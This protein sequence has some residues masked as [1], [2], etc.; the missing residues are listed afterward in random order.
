[1]YVERFT[2]FVDFIHLWSWDLQTTAKSKIMTD[3]ER[4]ILVSEEY[5]FVSFHVSRTVHAIFPF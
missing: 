3:S 5:F 4:T 2:R 1:M